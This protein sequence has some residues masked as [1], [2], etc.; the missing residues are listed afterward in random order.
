MPSRARTTDAVKIL[1][2]R[3]VKDDAA[4]EASVQL[5][6]VNTEVARLIY[7]LRSDAGL[8]QE[9]LARLVGTT[10][11][12]IS[13][14]EDSD[15]QGHSLSM[16]QKIAEA[17]KQK[18]TVVLTAKDPQTGTVRYAFHRL[19]QML[20]RG[21]G[22]TVDDLAKRARIDRQEI[23]AMEMNNAYRPSGPTIRRLSQFYGL[24]ER[25]LAM[26]AGAVED[27]PSEVREEASRFAAQSESSA[28]LTRGEKQLLDRFMSFLKTEE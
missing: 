25:R 19:M 9:E 18:L 27:V 11:S 6:R 3:Y 17:L 7:N 20:R 4:R 23:I 12:A 21:R 15:Y 22:L 10:Q 16:L 14:L 28:K 24:P 1:H 2:D 26:L 5:E 13:R 8:T